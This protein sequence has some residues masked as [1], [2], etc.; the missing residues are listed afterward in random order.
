MPPLPRFCLWITWMAGDLESPAWPRPAPL[1]MRGS[2]RWPGLTWGFP[3]RE[4]NKERKREQINTAR[5]WF[6]PWTSS[7][8]SQQ[9]RPTGD[10]GQKRK[11]VLSPSPGHGIWPVPWSLLLEHEGL[12]CGDCSDPLFCFFG[13]QD[14]V[15]PNMETH[16]KLLVCQVTLSDVLCPWNV[17]QTAGPNKRSPISKHRK[18]NL[19]Q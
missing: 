12:E 6:T 18:G 1:L 2:P 19:L 9:T 4:P 17:A 13:A 10:K 8:R 7:W 3:S 11:P 16:L 5:F 15:Q 14:S